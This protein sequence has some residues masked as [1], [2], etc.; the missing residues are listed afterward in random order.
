MCERAERGQ[1]SGRRRVDATEEVKVNRL[2][3]KN[4]LQVEVGSKEGFGRG[5]QNP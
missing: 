3:I 4:N 2:R 5:I 1:T